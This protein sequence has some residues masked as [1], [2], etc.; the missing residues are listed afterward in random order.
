MS[1]PARGEWIEIEKM[2]FFS[3]APG[4]APPGASGLKCRSLKLYTRKGGLAPP[5]ASGLKLR[6]RLEWLSQLRIWQCWHCT[7]ERCGGES[8]GGTVQ[9]PKRW[10]LRM[11][12]VP[13]SY[14]VHLWRFRAARQRR[15]NRQHVWRRLSHGGLLESLIRPER[16]P[17]EACEP[18]GFTSF[19]VG[20]PKGNTAQIRCVALPK[21]ARG[22]G[23]TAAALL[24]VMHDGREAASPFLPVNGGSPRPA[25]PSTAKPSLSFRSASYAFPSLPKSL[26][27]AAQASFMAFS[28]S[29]LRSV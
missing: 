5:G 26:S 29:R 2:R 28:A 22:R 9:R 20:Q 11:W 1:R 3:A 6:L 25:L 17:Q 19:R 16:S 7:I 21:R 18:L 10:M 13:P 27:L 8:R 14:K 15:A 23:F 24:I 12:P 4:L